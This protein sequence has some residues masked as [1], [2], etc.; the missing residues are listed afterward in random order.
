YIRIGNFQAYYDAEGNP[1]KISYDG[2]VYLHEGKVITHDCESE[3]AMLA[4]VN[5]ARERYA[6][7]EEQYVD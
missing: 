3:E 4:K 2:N 6:D 1:M 5:Y 7:F